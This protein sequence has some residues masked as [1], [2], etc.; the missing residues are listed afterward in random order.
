M[1]SHETNLLPDSVNLAWV[2]RIFDDSKMANRLPERLIH[3]RHRRSDFSTL[4]VANISLIRPLTF[5]EHN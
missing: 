4:I 2:V 3:E 1:M 5:Q